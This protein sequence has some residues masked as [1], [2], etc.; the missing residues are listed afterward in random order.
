MYTQN[1]LYFL[2][3]MDRKVK[4]YMRT[5][6]LRAVAKV[7]VGRVVVLVDVRVLSPVVLYFLT[8]F[9]ATSLVDSD[10]ASYVSS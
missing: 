6:D 9:R 4:S 8:V 2:V 7:F 3:S 5:C 10:M 1:R